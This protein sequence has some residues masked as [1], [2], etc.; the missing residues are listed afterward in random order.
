MVPS[1]QPPQLAGPHVVAVT[2]APPK[3]VWLL[4]HC[5]QTPA[6]EPHARLELPGVQAPASEM[7]PG[8][9]KLMHWPIVLQALFCA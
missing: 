1:Q 7:Q 2:Q 4:A 9:T 6:S 8:Q 3:Q 5:A